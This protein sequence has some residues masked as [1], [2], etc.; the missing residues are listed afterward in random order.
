MPLQW[1][2]QIW[3][4]DHG[5]SHGKQCAASMTPLEMAFNLCHKWLQ[6]WQTKCN[7]N[8]T[9]R[10]GIQFKWLYPCK[11]YVTPMTPSDMAFNLCRKWLQ[12]WQ[13]ICHF[14]DTIRCITQLIFEISSKVASHIYLFMLSTSSARKVSKLGPE[15]RVDTS[16]EGRGHAKMNVNSPS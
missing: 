9:I 10:Y 5:Y 1:L 16:L 12:P 8:D 4:S 7:F 14:N 3:H 6:S 2:H 15:V 13:T 11:R